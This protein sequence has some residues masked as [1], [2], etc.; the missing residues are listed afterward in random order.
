MT[1]WLAVCHTELS[2]TINSATNSP[3]CLRNMFNYIRPCLCHKLFLCSVQQMSVLFLD[4]LVLVLIR[5]LRTIRASHIKLIFLAA[6]IIFLTFM[7][8]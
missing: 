7:K 3:I 1:A 8:V 6:E 5:F 2:F 4:G